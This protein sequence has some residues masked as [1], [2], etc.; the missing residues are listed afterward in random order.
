M[1]VSGEISFFRTEPLEDPVAAGIALLDV[2]QVEKCDSAFASK[3]CTQE[4]GQFIQRSQYDETKNL[5]DPRGY[6]RQ[7]A[8]RDR[9]VGFYVPSLPIIGEFTFALQKGIPKSVLGNFY[10]SSCA[11]GVGMSDVM[12]WEFTM[13]DCLD[14]SRRSYADVTFFGRNY[15]GDPERF[16]HELGKLLFVRSLQ[17]RIESALGP[18]NIAAWWET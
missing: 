16:R 8:R 14:V 17:V 7:H 18:I 10:V 15:T 13:D 3:I 5:L 12:D 1:S 9:E 2:L 4:P 6:I 11:I